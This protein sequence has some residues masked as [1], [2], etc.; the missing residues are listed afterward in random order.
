MLTYFCFPYKFTGKELDPETGLYYY[1]ARYLDSAI[2]AAFPILLTYLRSFL[3]SF[4][5][6]D[7][8]YGSKFYYCGATSYYPLCFN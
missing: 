5:L 7:L 2:I 1:G 8:I 4:F 3:K 6:L